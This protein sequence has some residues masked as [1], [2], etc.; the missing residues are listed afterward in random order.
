MLKV[1]AGLALA[2]GAAPAWAASQPTDF[3][4][5][6]V[7]GE[8]ALASEPAAAASVA[9]AAAVPGGRISLTAAASLGSQWGRVTSTWRSRE[10]NRRVGGVRNSFHLS[11]RAIDIARR[12]GVSHAQ[13]AAAFRNAGYRLIESLDEGDHSHFAF[14][15]GAAA[16]SY[17]PLQQQRT[18]ATQWRVVT[19]ASA[20]LK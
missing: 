14:G 2:A 5:R 6:A 8:A 15:T 10:H 18:A 12:P 7:S 3:G 20:I 9:T 13:I 16:P 11:G 17:R 19:A 4:V 1:L